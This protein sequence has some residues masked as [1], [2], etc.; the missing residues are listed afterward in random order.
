MPDPLI[1]EI[2]LAGA[3]GNDPVAGPAALPPPVPKGEVRPFEER[4]EL[5]RLQRM[6][7]ASL[8]ILA[9]AAV[10]SLMYLAKLILVVILTAVLL[11]FVLAPVVDAVSN[12]RI[13]RAL[14][15]FLAVILLVGTIATVSY[16][17]YA[18]AVDF[19]SQMPQYRT[20]L[21]RIVKDIRQRAE[22]FEKTTET[23]LPPEPEDKNAVTVREPSSLRNLV[24]RNMSAVSEML[25]AVSFVPFLIYFMLSWQDH[26][27]ASS[28]MLF[29]MENRNTAYVTLGLIAAMI[30]SFIVGNF[31]I[32]LFL[33]AASMAA[34]GLMGL[35]YFYFLGVISGFLSLV[36]Y[37]GVFLAILPPVIVGLGYLTTA[38]FILACGV[39]VGL[40]LFAMNVLYP[41]V[42]GKRLQLNPLAVTIALLFWGWLWGAMGLILAVPLT[43]ALKIICDNIQPLRPYGA[44]MGE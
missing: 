1:D 28:V 33:S 23:V 2:R 22:Q 31:V 38:T 3:T 43:G 8:V 6:Q 39:V 35:P 37:L 11:A 32:G 24:S 13:P 25:L 14:G 21:Q 19:V 36:P 16:L 26:V 10:L 41:M 40:H 30:R 5:R 20:R 18:R 44:W 34:F 42:L 7:A 4:Q 15:A 17:S 29:R 27:R 12:F 9:T